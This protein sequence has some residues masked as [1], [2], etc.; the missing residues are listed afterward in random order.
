MVTE[1]AGGYQLLLPAGLAVMISYVLQVWLTS[2][3]K[4]R[5]LYEGQV[6]TREDSPAHYL[7]H[8]QLA[9]NLLGRRDIPLTDK[10]GRIDLLR[11]LR[12]R[13]R[14]DLPGGRQL[15]MCVISETSPLVGKTIGMLYQQLGENDFELVATMRR[16]HVLLPHADTFLETVIA[17]IVSIASPA[18]QEALAK[19]LGPTSQIDKN[20]IQI[21][22]SDLAA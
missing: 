1:M 9:L 14:F 19:Y 16:E 20:G 13:I 21:P 12:S 22:L 7:E 2:Y 17:R 11:L 3:L 15:T 6:P 5:S 10:L 4:Y 18:A 8:I